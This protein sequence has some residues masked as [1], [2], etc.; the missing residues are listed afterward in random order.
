MVTGP[1]PMWDAVQGSTIGL[2]SGRAGGSQAIAGNDT[3]HP[4]SNNTQMLV[5]Q[6]GINDQTIIVSF[7]FEQDGPLLGTATGFGIQGLDV[8]SPQ[9]TVA[10]RQDGVIVVTSGGLAGTQVAL[11]AGAFSHATWHSSHIIVSSD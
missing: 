7:A 8:W 10:F 9:W 5:K 3:G 2:L 4:L 11:F 1:T 6:I